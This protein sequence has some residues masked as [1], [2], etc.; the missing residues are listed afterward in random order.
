MK[1]FFLIALIVI[2]S[3]FLIY[4]I[5]PKSNVDRNATVELTLIYDEQD[6]HIVLPED[7]AYQIRKILDG[8]LFYLFPG[9]PACGFTKNYSFKIGNTFYA[10]AIDNCNTIMAYESER[11]IGVSQKEIEYIH[12]LFQKYDG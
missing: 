10:I 1:R 6:I 7:E 8:N 9:T 5:I 2:L 12:S 4:C 3:A 11:Y